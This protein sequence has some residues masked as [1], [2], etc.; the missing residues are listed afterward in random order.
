MRGWLAASLTEWMVRDAGRPTVGRQRQQRARRRR[1]GCRHCRRGGEAEAESGGTAPDHR[2]PAHAGIAMPGALSRLLQHSHLQRNGWQPCPQGRTTLDTVHLHLP[3]VS[4]MWPALLYLVC[5]RVSVEA[6]I[7]LEGLLYLAGTT[8]HVRL[9]AP[10]L[11]GAVT[12]KRSR[13][14]R[15]VMCATGS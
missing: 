9:C 14:S 2:H 6:C 3:P 8:E 13:A 7:C 1:W 15:C 4:F 11:L 12:I 10:E 5:S